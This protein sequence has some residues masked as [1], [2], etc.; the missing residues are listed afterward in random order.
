MSEKRK[1]NGQSRPEDFLLPRF[2]DVELPSGMHAKLRP[3]CLDMWILSGDLPG[4]LL[5]QSKALQN[6]SNEEMLAPS[7]QERLAWMHHVICY[8]FAEPK[9]STTDEPGTFHPSQL[10]SEDRAFVSAWVNQFNTGGGG[11]GL[12]NFRGQDRKPR[13]DGP[14]SEEVRKSTE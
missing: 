1:T 5:S 14:G 12:V 10:R 13:S 7:P 3:P 2:E 11:D 4:R 9:F 6:G 8:V